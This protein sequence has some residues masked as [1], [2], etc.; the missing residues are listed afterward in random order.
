M[1]PILLCRGVCWQ[2]PNMG[3]YHPGASRKVPPPP[4][5]AIPSFHQ[6]SCPPKSAILGHCSPPPL[7]RPCLPVM[8]LLSLNLYPFAVANACQQ[9]G[10]RLVALKTQPNVTIVIA[11]QAHEGRQSN[12]HNVI[13]PFTSLV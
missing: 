9:T 4:P 6:M 3:K 12:V 10:N 1:A 8:M 7:L 2:G 5:P 11:K 13:I